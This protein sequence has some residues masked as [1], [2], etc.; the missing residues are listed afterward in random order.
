MFVI[1]S[2]EI[3][4]TLWNRDAVIAG[5]PFYNI[6]IRVLNN[7]NMMCRQMCTW[8]EGWHYSVRHIHFEWR[9]NL[10]VYVYITLFVDYSIHTRQFATRHVI[11][12]SQIL[13]APR[14][15]NHTLLLRCAQNQ[16][17]IRCV[18]MCVF[19]CA[20]F[21]GSPFQQPKQHGKQITA[22]TNT[23]TTTSGLIT[24]V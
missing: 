4:L 3:N 24:A 16:W 19:S 11:L 9:S 5:I 1:H 14:T 18:I 12:I 13:C 2:C 22:T 8:C 10:D 20:H 23:S 21:C 6:S 17:T 15:T 7:D